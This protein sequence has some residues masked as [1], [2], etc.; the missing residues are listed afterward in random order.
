MPAKIVKGSQSLITPFDDHNV[1]MSALNGNVIASALNVFHQTCKL[2]CIAE[3]KG[4][5]FVKPFLGS[6]GFNW[7]NGH[8]A[9]LIHRIVCFV[10]QK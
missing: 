9:L 1:L 4:L 8:G 3:N 7:E 5:F 6:V 10:L 2:P